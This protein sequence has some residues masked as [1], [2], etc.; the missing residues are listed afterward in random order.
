MQFSDLRK[1]L[2]LLLGQI[3]I[4]LLFHNILISQFCI[5]WVNYQGLLE[6]CLVGKLVDGPEPPAKAPAAKAPP[7]VQSPAGGCPPA[8]PAGI[9]KHLRDKTQDHWVP[10]PLA[11]LH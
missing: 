3:I 10:A 8:G 2:T 1:Y 5:R 4:S 6:A 11:L 7:A 9:C